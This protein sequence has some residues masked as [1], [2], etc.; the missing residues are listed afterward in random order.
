MR[1]KWIVAAVGTGA[2]AGRCATRRGAAERYEDPWATPTATRP[3]SS[4]SRSASPKGAE[5]PVQRRAR[6]EADRSAPT[7]RRTRT[8]SSSHVDMTRDGQTMPVRHRGRVRLHRSAHMR[9]TLPMQSR[10]AGCFLV[11][12]TTCTE[13][14]VDVDA[15][16]PV[17]H[18]HARPQA[19][20]RPRRRSL[21]SGAGCGRDRRTEEM[22]GDV[23]P[24]RGRT[25]RGVYQLHYRSRGRR[26]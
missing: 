24:R 6:A 12:D 18:L 15:D 4:R 21:L 17:F 5:H 13:Y 3:T 1:K 11:T 10:Q 7:G 8:S 26:L 20:R 2:R 9:C 19:H 22:D 16:G 14:V 25:A 23:S